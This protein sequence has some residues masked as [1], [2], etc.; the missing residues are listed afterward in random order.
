MEEPILSYFMLS[1]IKIEKNIKYPSRKDLVKNQSEK[2]YY[3]FKM[4]NERKKLASEATE[5]LKK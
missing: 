1:F 5:N 3:K 2:E 4:L